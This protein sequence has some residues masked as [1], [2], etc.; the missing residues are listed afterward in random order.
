MSWAVHSAPSFN[1]TRPGRSYQQ[2]SG[3]GQRFMLT[4]DSRLL[5]PGTKE[6]LL[7]AETMTGTYKRKRRG[8]AARKRKPVA[9]KT[10]IMPHYNNNPET[11]IVK[12]ALKQPKLVKGK[13]RVK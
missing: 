4:Q 13:R 5:T 6:K 8:K 7:P 12:P 3:F 2:L 10:L 1:I 11:I 9:N